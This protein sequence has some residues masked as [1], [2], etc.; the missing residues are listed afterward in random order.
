MNFKYG[1]QKAREGAKAMSLAF[2]LLNFEHTSVIIYQTIVSGT[3]RVGSETGLG[4][5]QD[6]NGVT[7]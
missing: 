2:V 4:Y 3:L 5:K 6:H 1:V 7:V